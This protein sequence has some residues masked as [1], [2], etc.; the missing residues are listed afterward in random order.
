MTTRMFGYPSDLHNNTRRTALVP[1][2][3]MAN[4]ADRGMISGSSIATGFLPGD[5]T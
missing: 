5:V 1:V 2:L 3:D 4:C